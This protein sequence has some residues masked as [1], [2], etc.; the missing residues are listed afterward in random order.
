[1][2]SGDSSYYVAR[3]G[4]RSVGKICWWRYRKINVY[5]G[6]NW[7]VE[8]NTCQTENTQSHKSTLTPSWVHSNQLICWSTYANWFSSHRTC[9]L[10]VLNENSTS[11]FNGLNNESSRKKRVLRWKR[12]NS[13]E[14]TFFFRDQP[15]KAPAETSAVLAQRRIAVAEVNSAP[16]T[17]ATYPRMSPYEWGA[18]L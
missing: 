2:R 7:R 3:M 17:P 5:T 16:L 15:S 13:I 1:M 9:I 12:D 8:K 11:H 10:Q 6:L 4:P 18:L 14:K